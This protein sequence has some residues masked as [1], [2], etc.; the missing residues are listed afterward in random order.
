MKVLLTTLLL[1]FASPVFAHKVI[2]IADGD[3]LTLLVD[4]KP[5]KVRLANIDAPEKAQPF[6]NRSRQSLA[7]LCFGEDA[8]YETQDIDRY[9]RSV[10]VVTCGDV[11][12]NKTQ[13]ERGMAW[14]YSKY[15]KDPA[16]PDLQDKAREER[17]GIWSDH[18]PIP[19]WEFRRSKRGGNDK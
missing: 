12:V 15:N 8:T 13:V 18:S 1:G 5:L 9:G 11:E 3:T 17:R 14:V 10:A 4:N 7:E 6:G 2:G 19:P 16:L